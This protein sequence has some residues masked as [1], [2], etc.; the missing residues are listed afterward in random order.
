MAPP[1]LISSSFFPSFFCVCALNSI[2]LFGIN[3]F[4]NWPTLMCKYIVIRVCVLLSTHKPGSLWH[5]SDSLTVNNGTMSKFGFNLSYTVA[6]QWQGGGGGG[7]GGSN[8]TCK[9]IS[10]TPIDPSWGGPIELFL[11]PASA[12]RLV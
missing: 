10:T 9:C 12:P 5:W 4:T 7:R 2:Y 1:W 3:C 11:I 6:E 8:F